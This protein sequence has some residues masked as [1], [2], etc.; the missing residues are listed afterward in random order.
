MLTL[1]IGR[2][3]GVWLCAAVISL[4]AGIH[5]FNKMADAY[6]SKFCG[7]RRKRSDSKSPAL[8]NLTRG[9]TPFYSRGMVLPMTGVDKN[10]F[11][12]VEAAIADFAAGRIVVVVDDEKR[13]NEGDMIA[14]IDKLTVQSV[15]MMLR[16]ACGLICVPLAGKQL[17]RLNLPEMTKFNRDKF[18]T[19]FIV[20]VDAAKGITTGISA[21]D[22]WAT[23]K[24]LGDP[25]STPEMLAQP[26]HMFPLKARDGGVLE[27]PGHTEATVDLARLAGLN[28]AG[29]CCEILNED[30]S[31][32]RLPQLVEFK[33][34]HGLKLISVADIAAYRLAHK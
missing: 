27:R 34:L 13:E 33:K 24:V 22:R 15:N 12:T 1:R 32:M 16:H 29:L 4:A 10:V 8:R 26:G 9:F 19:A 3:R 14:S 11:D 20:S 6:G 2:D 28:P 18:S 7:C 31:C 21:H 5:W 30:G 25:A 23:A 17:A